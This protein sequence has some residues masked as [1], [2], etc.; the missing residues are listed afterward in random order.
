LE[1]ARA[2]LV[3]V[4]QQVRAIGVPSDAGATI[5]NPP[6][7]NRPSHERNM[8]LFFRVNRAVLSALEW[9]RQQ[10]TMD[11]KVYAKL[12]SLFRF[13]KG[14]DGIA[15]LHHE[16][17]QSAPVSGGAQEELRAQQR[18]GLQLL[19]GSLDLPVQQN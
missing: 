4:A 14:L 17:P 12:A 8:V 5:E 1:A 13:Y 3:D 15:E 18:E 10:P 6:D 19:V 9:A 11:A 16:V 7:Q 2:H